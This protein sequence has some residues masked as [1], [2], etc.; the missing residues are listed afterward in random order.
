[1]YIFYQILYFLHKVWCSDSS[2][3]EDLTCKK[4]DAMLCH[5]V[6]VISLGL[7]GLEDD[8]SKWQEP[9]AQTRIGISQ[10]PS[11][12]MFLWLY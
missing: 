12:C 3:C 6:N 11:V 2:V 10:K 5:W 4:Y 1:V 7:L 9:F 8:P